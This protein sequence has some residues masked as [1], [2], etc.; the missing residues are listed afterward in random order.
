MSNPTTPQNQT[1]FDLFLDREVSK[2]KFAWKDVSKFPL[3]QVVNAWHIA[4]NR[5]V[6]DYKDMKPELTEN[7]CKYLLRDPSFKGDLDKGILIIG[8]PGTGKTKYTEI[9]GIM[10]KYLHFKEISTYTAKEMENILKLKPESEP[11][12]T[13]WGEVMT[14]SV[15]VFDDIGMES[16]VVKS[17]GSEINI[18][19]DVLNARHH[20]FMQK[21]YL[22]VATSNLRVKTSDPMLKNTTFMHRYGERIDSRIHELFNVFSLQGDDL[23]KK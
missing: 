2:R 7:L 5:M 8:P 1:D 20:A 12:Q 13:L 9:F 15:F 4:G 11:V 14:S 16:A 18:G 6:Q 21:G 23:R 3:H 19:V 10:L 17:M 22:T